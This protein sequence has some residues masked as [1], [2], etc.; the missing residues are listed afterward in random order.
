MKKRSTNGSILT[1]IVFIWT[2]ANT[3]NRFFIIAGVASILG[4]LVALI[5]GIASL[6]PKPINGHE[7]N[8][9][10]D[11][12]EV[13]STSKPTGESAATATQ[14]STSGANV[15]STP[16]SEPQPPLLS[17]VGVWDLDEESSGVRLYP[18]FR[19]IAAVSPS[20]EDKTYVVAAGLS[21][22]SLALFGM[23]DSRFLQIGRQP[24]VWVTDLAFSPDGDYLYTG[25]NN[26]EFD[27]W[28]I[29]NSGAKLKRTVFLESA[30]NA[31]A[32]SADNSFV[33]IGLSH[34]AEDADENRSLVKFINPA[35]NPLSS[36]IPQKDTGQGYIWG[37]DINT[38]NML[39]SVGSS[40]YVRWY[41]FDPKQN[42]FNQRGHPRIGMS[43]ARAV[44]FPNLI[45]GQFA[46]VGDNFGIVH[47]VD[48][49][50]SEVVADSK[51]LGS[52]IKSLVYHPSLN[53]LAVGTDDCRVFLL[54]D[55]LHQLARSEYLCD[56]N[57]STD[58]I[59]SIDFSPDGNYLLIAVSSRI[60][61]LNT[62]MNQTR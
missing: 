44:A 49:G 4:L 29:D 10:F 8:V 15:E 14:E 31:I 54:D 22:G 23:D 61:L 25:S 24:D 21:D 39:I 52:E 56:E 17:V 28:L 42:A 55:K 9:I 53:V 16:T 38:D 47:L 48:L 50:T 59:T 43:F 57:D 46:A 20:A 27:V 1:K 41:E 34:I 19:T 13:T 51:P 2:D 40:R 5:F 37:I 45:D 62:S 36:S 35:T 6:L 11:T 33:A 7:E 30:I 60:I 58:D 12:E 3:L 32:V 26:W 18:S